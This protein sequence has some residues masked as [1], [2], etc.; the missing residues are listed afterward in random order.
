MRKPEH[1][2]RCEGNCEKVHGSHK[3]RVKRIRA[4]KGMTDFGV[5]YCCLYE[6]ERYEAEGYEVEE[7]QG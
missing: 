2:Y 1:E 5:L 4:T 6:I 3:G 7:L